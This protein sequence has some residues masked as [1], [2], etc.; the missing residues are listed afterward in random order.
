M[1]FL[2]GSITLAIVV[3]VVT[4]FPPRMLITFIGSSGFDIIDKYFCAEKI[5]VIAITTIQVITMQ[6]VYYR[7]IIILVVTVMVDN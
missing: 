2:A 7:I 3:S 4:T 5:N 6:V 1:G